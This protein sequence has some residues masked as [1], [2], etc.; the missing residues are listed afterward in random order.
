ML[1]LAEDR[2][3]K[4]TLAR[5][6]ADDL[7]EQ[8]LNGDLEPGK[9]LN[10]VQM[11][12]AYN[13][14]STSLREAV[15]RLVS[16]G[17]VVAEE[18]R[19]YHVTPV[20]QTNLAEVTQLLIRLEALALRASIENGG[21][22]WETEVMSALYRLNRAERR[23]NDSASLEAWETE[24][25]KFH[26]SLINRSGMPMALTPLF[27]PRKSGGSSIWA[28]PG[29][30]AHNPSPGCEPMLFAAPNFAC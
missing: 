29:F 30:R 16:D 6:L 12:D 9:K 20:S 13:V 17:L 23:P 3:G 25:R 27:A 7:R 11:K 5:R 4:P 21:L 26:V 18:Q 14:S 24:H 15:T 28:G 2:R 8:I 1:R 19:A 22:D 10:L